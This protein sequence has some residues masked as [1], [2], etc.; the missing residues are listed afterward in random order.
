MN[1]A[2]A[3]VKQNMEGAEVLNAFFTSV[4]TGKTALQESKALDTRGEVWRKED[5]HLVREDQVREHLSKLD[6][7]RPMD[8]DGVH[9]IAEEPGR[10]HCRF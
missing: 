10:C 5:L 1:T 7:C 8:P 3:L 2:G 6:I 4:F 9:L